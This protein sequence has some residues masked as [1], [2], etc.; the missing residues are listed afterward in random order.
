VAL[1]GVIEH[2]LAAMQLFYDLRLGYL[3]QTPG[4]ETP[5][6]A[7]TAKAGDV[8]AIA[9]QFG[10]SDAG[11]NATTIFSAGTWE[12]E[13]LPNGSVIKIGLKEDGQY[14]DGAILALNQTWTRDDENET[15]NG[16]FNLNTVEINDA[17]NRLDEDAED[18]VDSISCQLEVTFQPGGIGGWRSSVLPVDLLLYHDII[19][20]N[21]GT[22]TNADNPE[23]YLLRADAASTAAG[24]GASLI[25]IEDEAENF[26]G[27]T[28][29]D[30]LAELATMGSATLTGAEIKT[31]YEGEEDTNAFT[32]DEKSKLSAISGTNTGDQDL[33]GYVLTSAI[34]TLAEINGIITDATLIDTN[35]A[36]LSDSRTPTSHAS[37]HVTG[38]SDKLR[39]ATASQDGLM[40]SAYASKLDGIEASANNYIL[41]APT[42]TTLGGVKRNTGSAGQFVTGIDTDGSLLR[43]TISGGGDALTSGT[44]DQFTDVTQTAGKTLAITESTTLAGGTHSGT[45]TGDQDLSG[46][47]LTESINTL[48]ELNAVV[49]D[50]TLIDTNDARLSD[51][52]TPTSH[53]HGNLTNGGAIGTTSGL[54]IKTGTSG[55]LEAGAFGTSAGQFAEGNHTHSQLHDRSH[56]ITS[57]SDHTAGNHKVF[58]SNGSGEV[59][60]LALGADGTYLKSNGSTSAPSFETPSGGGGGSKTLARFT[61]RDN[62]PPASNFATLDTRNSI[63]VLDFDAATKE[64]AVFVGVIPQGADLTSGLSISIFWMATTATSGDC[65]W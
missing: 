46:Y 5:V 23:D 8:E 18:D 33:S 54:P 30:A 61:T 12:P 14:S 43:D 52:R 47:V 4:L 64:T 55:V 56:A 11:E 21:E 19:G 60:E 48:S 59:T 7:F 62:Q 32:D 44:L 51:A 57:T 40:T 58:Y 65:I 31:L 45:N 24:F 6:E 20:G 34:D 16:E 50:A 3:V 22:P 2:N 53:T 25:G 9:L 28:V 63:A 49:T 17:L 27:E 10:R 37:S 41:P 36:R 39:D 42:T 13:T 1:F 26:T 38:G 29:E 35:D 15:Y